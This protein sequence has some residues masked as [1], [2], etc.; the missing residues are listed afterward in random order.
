MKTIVDIPVLFLPFA[1]PHYARLVFDSIKKAKP[2]KL[3]FYSDKAREGYDEEL[4]NNNII[5]NYISE[6]DWDCNLKTWFRDENVGVYD[7]I[8]NAIDWFFDNEEQG[9]ILEED[10]MPSLSFFDFC[11]QLLEKYK[12]DKR[13]WYIGG[14]NLIQ[15]YYNGGFDYY[16]TPFAY[17]WG[18][19]TWADRWKKVNRTGFNTMIIKEYSLYDQIYANSD[20]AK[21]AY[22]WLQKRSG[23]DQLFLPRSWDYLFNMTMR[24]NGGFGIAPKNNLVSNIGIKG[25]NSQVE[26]KTYHNK[27][28]P[29]STEYK[30][31]NEPPFVVSDFKYNQVFINKILLRKDFIIT[32][33]I[34]TIFK[35]LNIK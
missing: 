20:A 33:I 6:V 7:S 27:S 14:N 16:F 24:C 21:N 11:R 13:I 1:R 5:R 22:E 12:Y 9:I 29:L 3:Y 15:D 2:K 32:K 30:I 28:I 34:K 8:L 18:W 4:M 31:T 26:N 17:Q 35:K 25:V 23:K 10:C 19:A